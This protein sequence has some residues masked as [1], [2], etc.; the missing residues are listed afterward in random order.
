MNS[1][2]V[3]R[4]A[5]LPDRLSLKTNGATTLP[6]TLDSSQAGERPLESIRTRDF[7]FSDIAEP[8]R[9][10]GKEILKRHAE[11]RSLSGRNA[12][13][14]LL[15]LCV[16]AF[17]VGLAWALRGQPVWAIVLCAF[18][19]FLFLRDLS[20]WSRTVRKERGGAGDSTP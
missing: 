4:V 20:L 5:P 7:V 8:H 17:Q 6:S 9:S 15:I 14:A 16:V 13:S 10:R 12:W 1:L 19:S 11:I 18:F 3:N 2:F